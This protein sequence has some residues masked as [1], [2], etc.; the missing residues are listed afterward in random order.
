MPQKA[1]V[2]VLLTEVAKVACYTAVTARSTC[3][4]ENQT[5]FCFYREEATAERAAFP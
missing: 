5:S 3:S 4:S 1:Q 2:I